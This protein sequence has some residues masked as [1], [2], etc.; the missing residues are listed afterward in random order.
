VATL[1]DYELEKKVTV[2]DA[3]VGDRV[4]AGTHGF[5]KDSKLYM[6]DP[7]GQIYTIPAESGHKALAEGYRVATGPE[8]EQE[9][10]KQYVDES[11][12]TAGLLGFLRTMSFGLS[13]EVLQQVGVPQE[14]I[15][16]HREMNPQAS[17]AGEIGGLVSPGSI[18]GAG[19]RLFGKGLLR[20]SP[21]A[22]KQSRILSGAVG[23]A[24]E[25]L[26]STMPMAV[27]DSILD[28]Q[29]APTVA[30]HALAGMGWG[31]AAGGVIGSLSRM[32]TGSQKQL[33]KWADKLFFRSLQARKPEVKRLTGGGKYNERI[34]DLG[35]RLRELDEQE[36]LKLGDLE[37]MYKQ[38]GN[39][40]LPQTGKR[41]NELIA[42]IGQIQ[43]DYSRE[44][45][46][47]LF[48]PK[49][50][51]QRMREKI[52]TGPLDPQAAMPKALRKKIR[53][54]QNLIDEFE[55]TAPGDFV[56]LEELKRQYQYLARQA[57]EYGKVPT[58]EHVYR[59]MA[60]IIREEA[61]QSLIRLEEKLGVFAKPN[62]QGV[63]VPQSLV[64]EFIETKGL[65][66]DLASLDDILRESVLR[67]TV[68]NTLPLTSFITG[69]GLGSGL[70]AAS[71]SLLTGGALAAGGF[72]AGALIR[73]YLKENG[74]LLMARGLSRLST[75]GGVLETTG[76]ASARIGKNVNRLIRGTTPV[77]RPEYKDDKS[78]T[79]NFGVIRKG[80]AQL[81]D[82]VVLQSRLALLN[83]GMDGD[84]A[85][86]AA[87]QQTLVRSVAYLATNLPKS[88]T[89]QTSLVPDLQQLPSMAEMRQFLR[90]VEVVNDPI[91]AL[92]HVAA[93]TL[94][95]E[96]VDALKTVYPALYQSMLHQTLAG[97]A[98]AGTAKLSLQQRIALSKFAGKAVDASLA[99][100]QLL[101]QMIQQEQQPMQPRGR[102]IRPASFETQAQAAQIIG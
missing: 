24:G 96:H 65:Y 41:L 80:V 32:T 49:E 46:D 74:E 42:E 97:I 47:V 3:E 14:V 98:D 39:D 95:L 51:A 15:R 8:V 63:Y 33:G 12:T 56:R 55:K 29:D 100:I 13:D 85:I 53:K 22:V 91:R 67:E 40:L 44:L 62:A 84:Q 5:L 94:T 76:Q 9:R 50:I 18:T 71:D 77:V 54:A 38:V 52:L 58:T 4:K 26:I 36:L 73:K 82:P 68:N 69:G 70:A 101:Q 64:A 7:Q 102:V 75:L 92:E 60:S 45:G 16:M 72:V 17:L 6:Y 27:S 48:R 28:M 57:G 79:K 89:L 81:S 99:N 37:E 23:G 19:A 83:Q 43:K 90:R 10:L 30:E 21:N 87:M 86:T 25:G 61:E 35:K 59:Q 93:G 31:T 78:V 34:M 20:L 66:A 2:P 88:P 11:P 1:Y